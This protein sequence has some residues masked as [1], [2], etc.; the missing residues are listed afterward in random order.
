MDIRL[1]T[2][3]VIKQSPVYQQANEEQRRRMLMNMGLSTGSTS[4]EKQVANED[5][6]NMNKETINKEK[7]KQVS[8]P[9]CKTIVKKTNISKHKKTEICKIKAENYRLRE[10][11][12]RLKKIVFGDTCLEIN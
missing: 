8:C 6:Y 7:N 12:D 2:I 3:E 1:Q 5:Y 9:L 11:N 4:V 10:E